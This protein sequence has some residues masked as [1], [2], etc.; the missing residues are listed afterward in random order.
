M[1]IFYKAI[2]LINEAVKAIA[3]CSHIRYYSILDKILK[4]KM[5]PRPLQVAGKS[6]ILISSSCQ[7]IS[8]KYLLNYVLILVYY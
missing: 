5:L 6:A 2:T 1:P 7:V 8:F 4:N 3:H